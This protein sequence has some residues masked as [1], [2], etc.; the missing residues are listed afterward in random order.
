MVGEYL[1]SIESLKKAVHQEPENPVYHFNL[2]NS[3]SE[4]EEFEE[5]IS[6]YL[7]AL[8]LDPSHL[9]SLTNLA[10][11]YEE[12]GDKNR[13]Y[14]LFSY[15]VKTDPDVPIYHF[16]FMILLLSHNIHIA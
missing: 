3:Y 2:G 12:H 16:I 1:L 9:G 8:E 5:A 6:C 15:I 10:H 13:A 4:V 11:C 14:D 7:K